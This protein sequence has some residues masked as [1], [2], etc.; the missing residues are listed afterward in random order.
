MSVRQEPFQLVLLGKEDL[1]SMAQQVRVTGLPFDQ[2][3]QGNR[4]KHL[5]AWYDRELCAGCPLVGTCQEHAPAGGDWEVLEAT[6]QEAV[7][8]RITSETMVP[9]R[10]KKIKT[11]APAAVRMQPKDRWV[12]LFD[13]NVFIGGAKGQFG[14]RL[15]PK[16]VLPPP[17]FEYWITQ[18]VFEEIRYLED[19]DD[20]SWLGRLQVQDDP[21]TIDPRIQETMGSDFTRG[22]R[23]DATL[24]QYALEHPEVDRIVSHDN[25]HLNSGLLQTLGIRDRVHAISPRDFIS[26]CERH[27]DY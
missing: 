26:L 3:W 4:L 14:K 20:A 23:Q 8:C 12:I 25:F 5:R 6:P 10:A 11:K 19:H 15:K 13:A 2:A 17:G 16:M 18:S 9:V 1:G 24:F 21:E 22:S 7:P 27:E